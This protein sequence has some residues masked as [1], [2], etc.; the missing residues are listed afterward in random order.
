MGTPLRLHDGTIIDTDTGRP[1]ADQPVSV[2][3]KELSGEYVAPV[4]RT[5]DDLPD[6]PQRCLI[7]ATIAALNVYGLRDTDIAEMCGITLAQVVTVRESDAFGKIRQTMVDNVG[8]FEAD[9]VK[10]ELRRAAPDAARNL[11]KIARG[12]LD[13]PM[14]LQAIGSVLD[15]AGYRPQ[16]NVKHNHQV[17]GGLVIE[18]VRRDNTRQLPTLNIA[19]EE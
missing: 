18:L 11:G 5:L 10:R 17:N 14:T 19:L 2:I 15:R 7:A 8:E 13:D 12:K 6:T 3:D 4:I 9:Q 16:E 1:V